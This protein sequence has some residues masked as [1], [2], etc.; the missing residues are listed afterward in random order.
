MGISTEETHEMN[1][2]MAREEGLLV[3]IS[4]ASAMVAALK[5]AQQAVERGESAII[6]T[7]FPD[8]AAKYL[9][10]HSEIYGA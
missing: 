7:L 9:S 2:R 3:G 5:V 10:S 4:A 1:L 8:S 6:V